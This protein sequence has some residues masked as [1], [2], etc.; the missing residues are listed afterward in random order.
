MGR[1]DSDGRA[2]GRRADHDRYAAID[3]YPD[4]ISV[5]HGDLYGYNYLHTI[6]DVYAV[7]DLHAFGDVY[8]FTHRFRYPNGHGHADWPDVLPGGYQSVDRAALSQ[9]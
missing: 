4:G 1:A 5:A 6:P 8:A 9:R 7:R 2:H 3:Q